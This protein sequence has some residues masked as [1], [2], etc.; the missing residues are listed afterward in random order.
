MIQALYHSLR[1]L[2]GGPACRF[3]PTCSDYAFQSFQNTGFWEAILL[4]GRRLLKCHPFHVGG[5]DLPPQA[6]EKSHE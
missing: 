6:T 4:T 5:L 1:P 2:L 3:Y